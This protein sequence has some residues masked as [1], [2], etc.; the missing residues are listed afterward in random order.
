MNKKNV[1]DFTEIELLAVENFHP[2]LNY[3]A[4]KTLLAFLLGEVFISGRENVG[5]GGAEGANE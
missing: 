4:D 1:Q 2:V 3:G 5:W